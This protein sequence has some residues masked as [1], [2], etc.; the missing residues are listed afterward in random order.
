MKEEVT[1]DGWS[2]E[3]AVVIL[4]SCVQLCN[5]VDCR[6]LGFPV[7]HYL[8]EFAQIYIH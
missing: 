1:N 2:K 3:T 7:L 5:P 8:L 4:L 6:M